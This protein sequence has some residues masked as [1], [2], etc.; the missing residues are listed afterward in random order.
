MVLAG[1]LPDAV[2]SIDGIT[3]ET[4]EVESADRDLEDDLEVRGDRSMAAVD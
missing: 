4:T 2:Y 1:L 3:Q